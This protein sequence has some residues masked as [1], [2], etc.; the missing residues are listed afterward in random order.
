M[1]IERHMF[2]NYAEETISVSITAYETVAI[3]GMLVEGDNAEQVSEEELVSPETEVEFNLRV[4][5]G[6]IWG[7]GVYGGA[8]YTN[9]NEEYLKI[10]IGDGKNP[11]PPPPPPPPL[12]EGKEDY[13]DRFAAFLMPLGAEAPAP[14]RDHVPEASPPGN[15]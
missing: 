14:G 3:Y 10:F 15:A 8:V 12:F 5:A 11:W 6:A 13:E 7:F 1:S 9:P 2:M 4:P